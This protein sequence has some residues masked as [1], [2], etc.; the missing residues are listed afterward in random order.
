MYEIFYVPPRG[1]GEWERLGSYVASGNNQGPALRLIRLRIPMAVNERTVSLKP[2]SPPCTLLS[3]RPYLG[4]LDTR[5]LL[6][7]LSK[8]G[9]AAV[10]RRRVSPA[11]AD[12]IQMS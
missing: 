5:Q 4:F 7:E 8:Q 1:G 9:Q 6:A 11:V 3:L 2:S 12:L 10:W